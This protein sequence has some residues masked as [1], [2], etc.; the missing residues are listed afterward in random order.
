MRTSAVGCSD[1]L[2]AIQPASIGSGWPRHLDCPSCQG[3]CTK[4]FP[5][6][7]PSRHRTTVS[8]ILLRH[9][10]S[11]FNL[12]Y[13]ATGIDPGIPDAPLTE[14]GHRQANAA[15]TSLAG[16]DIRRIICSPYTRALQ[17]ATPV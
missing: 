6:Q 9:G 14:L 13:N 11:E 8:M 17:T 12:H 3:V 10:Q 16:E 2:S 15:A 1:M 5:L 4:I 7:R